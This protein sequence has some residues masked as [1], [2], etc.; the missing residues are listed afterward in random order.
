MVGAVAVGVALVIMI[1]TRMSVDCVGFSNQKKKSHGG[2]THF[3]IPSQSSD[4]SSTASCVPPSTNQ[5]HLSLPLLL[6]V[7]PLQPFCQAH[8]R[9]SLAK[10]S[11]SKTQGSRKKGGKQKRSP[12]G[13]GALQSSRRCSFLNREQA[14][15]GPGG[16]AGSRCHNFELTRMVSFEDGR[17]GEPS[18]CISKVATLLPALAMPDH[19]EAAVSVDAATHRPLLFALH[20][21]NRA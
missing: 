6:L 14:R 21:L 1:I 18:P 8:I 7:C 19:V 20:L 3:R 17:F 9:P 4:S 10:N 13:T 2:L 16:T 12:R 15:A 5:W 11:T